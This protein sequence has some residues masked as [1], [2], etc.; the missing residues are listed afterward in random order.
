M[1]SQGIALGFF[2]ARRHV[3][4]CVG[5]AAICIA[6][7]LSA[8]AAFGYHRYT[9]DVW[10][11]QVNETLEHPLVDIGHGSRTFLKRI[12]DYPE[13]EK[14]N[15]ADS[16]VLMIAMEAGFRRRLYWFGL[17]Q[18]AIRSLVKTARHSVNQ[19]KQLFALAIAVMIVG[20]VTRNFFDY[21]FA[22]SLASVLDAPGNGSYGNGRR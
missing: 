16:A 5:G 15:G 2:T 6:A 1:V 11:L 19:E 20:F 4:A 13:A 18:A 8:L 3:I 7:S 12:G 21:M 17:L 22:G 14:A 9:L 10:K